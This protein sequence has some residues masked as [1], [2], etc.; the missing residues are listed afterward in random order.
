MTLSFILSSENQFLFGI[1]FKIMQGKGVTDRG[2][3]LQCNR[4][5]V[6]TISLFSSGIQTIESPGLLH[7]VSGA[8]PSSSTQKPFSLSEKGQAIVSSGGGIL[9][10]LVLRLQ[11]LQSREHILKLR[12]LSQL[13]QNC[14]L[15]Y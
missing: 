2:H 6:S 12:K 11:Q 13:Y 1:G 4:W 5:S 9:G 14:H 3:E 8:L 7:S 15:G 10:S